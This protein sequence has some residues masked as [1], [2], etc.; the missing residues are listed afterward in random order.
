MS[1]V[2]DLG[3]DAWSPWE[4]RANFSV[5]LGCPSFGGQR[6]VAAQSNIP[7]AEL[8]KKVKPLIGFMI[9]QC[10]RSRSK[11]GVGAAPGPVLPLWLRG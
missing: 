6:T 1:A 8:F 9:Q 10:L 3:L 2:Q 5:G 7:L 11:L 4:R